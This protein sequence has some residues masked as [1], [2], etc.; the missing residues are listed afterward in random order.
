LIKLDRVYFNFVEN[1]YPE[2]F[3]ED[4]SDVIASH[5]QGVLYL[6]NTPATSGFVEAWQDRVV[7][8]T[9]DASSENEFVVVEGYLLLPVLVAVQ[10]RLAGKA[11]VTTVEARNLQYFFTK[12]IEQIHGI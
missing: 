5:Y 11:I 2:L 9:E 10:K 1:Q 6:A 12:S 4:L 7:S 8:D 3:R